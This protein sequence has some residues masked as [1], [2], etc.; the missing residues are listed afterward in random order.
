M[1]VYNIL[2]ISLPFIRVSN[3]DSEGYSLSDYRGN[4]DVLEELN[5]D[6]VGEKE[7]ST[8]Q[9]NIKPR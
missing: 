6:P 7:I 5:S 8:V 4:E 9:R 3:L 1:K 2:A